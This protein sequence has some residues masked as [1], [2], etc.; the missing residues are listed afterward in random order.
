MASSRKCGG[1]VD[2]EQWD[3][4]EGWG[5]VRTAKGGDEDLAEGQRGGETGEP[6]PND[7]D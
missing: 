4:Q 1:V 6:A 2:T 5:T 7:N 3:M